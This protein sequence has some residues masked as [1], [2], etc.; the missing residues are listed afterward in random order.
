MGCMGRFQRTRGV[1]LFAEQRN[2]KRNPQRGRFEFARGV[3]GIESSPLG[4][5]R[6]GAS[7]KRGREAC[8]SLPPSRGVSHFPVSWGFPGKTRAE[9]PARSSDPSRT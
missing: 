9:A 6:R 1:A 7:S 8:S 4:I 2:K 5:S 3:R